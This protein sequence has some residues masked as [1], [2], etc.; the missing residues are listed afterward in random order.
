MPDSNFSGSANWLVLP[1]ADAVNAGFN[2][3]KFMD[4]NDLKALEAN[5]CGCDEQSNANTGASLSRQ[6]GDRDYR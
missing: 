3:L 2:T 5:D 1:N 4:R 6:N